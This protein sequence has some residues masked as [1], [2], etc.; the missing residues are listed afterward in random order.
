MVAFL[1]T[2]PLFSQE[3][4]IGNGTSVQVYP[5]GNYYGFER[6]ASL[7]QP[8]EIGNI[9][10]ISSLAWYANSGGFGSRPIKIYLKETTQNILT[11]SD[12]SSMITGATLVYD[13]SV[14]PLQGWNT[15]ILNTTFNYTGTTN[16]LLVLVEAN[17]GASGNGFG[18]S[19][20]NI[21]FSDAANKHMYIRGDYSAPT[22]MGT[23]TANRPNLKLKFGPLVTCFS[24]NGINA[25]S[26][27]T[28]TA[29]IS[30]SAAVPA[31]ANGY[32]YE[33]RTSGAAGSGST[34]LITSGT[35]A[36]G[37]TTVNITQLTNNTTYY[38]Y[39]RGI[40]SSTNMSIWSDSITFTTLCLSTNI[41]YNVPID[42][43]TIPA[44]PDCVVVENVNNDNRTWT[45][46]AAPSGFSGKAMRYLYHSTNV[47][48]DWFYTRGLNLTGGVSY[49][50]RFKYRNTGYVEKLR[51]SY[52]TATNNTA[53]TNELFAVVTQVTATTIEKFIDF[54]PA[55]TGV[56]YVG[57]QAFSDANKN[58]LYV[59]DIS[60]EL[61]P[62]CL[63]VTTVTIGSITQTTAT[64]NWMAPVPAPANGYSYEVRTS[65][66]AGSGTS[67]L[68]ASGTTGAGV[69]TA[70][71]V[72]L[73][74]NTT[75]YVYV[76][77]I[78][79]NTD[80]GLW[81]NGT[82]FTTLCN[83]TNIPYTMPI[84]A[85]VTPDIPAC[86]IVENVNNDDR[87][88]T[89]YPSPTGFT[90]KAM[91]YQYHST[92][93]ANDWFYTRGL[94]LTA[95]VSYRLK[96]KYRNVLYAE[97]LRVS[98]GT[99]QVNTA[100]LNEIFTVV[101]TNQTATV[102]KEIDFVPA[103]TGV[104]YI[105]FQAFSDANKNYLYVGDI[106]VELSPTCLEVSG[107]HVNSITETTAT[108]NWIAPATAPA[109]GYSYEI[110]TSGAAG[111]GTTGL[112]NSG[113]T[114]AGI[115]TVS[116]TQL[117]PSTT[118]YVYVRGVCNSTETGNWSASVTLTT[119]CVAV[120]I[121]YTVPVDA[122]TTPAIPD[123]V[124]VD[125]INNDNKTWISYATQPG[126]SGKVMGY[127]YHSTNAA[128]D[129]F[130]IRGLYMTAGVSYRLKFK[131]RNVLY[132]EKLRV[133][134]GTSQVNTAMLNEI[135]TV[136]TTSQTATVE[137][138]IDF[139]PTETGIHYI[140][141]QAFSDANKNYLYVGDISVELSPTCLDLSGVQINNITETSATIN[142]TAPVVP[143]IEGYSYEI[144]TSGAAGSGANG[145]I[146]SGTTAAGITT[147]TITQL[148]P[149]TTYYVY[150]RGICGG[151]TM[152][153]WTD[154][155]TFT[156]LCS[157]INVPYTVPIDAVTTPAIPDCVIVENVNNDNR[158]WESYN[159]PT[160]F[161]GKAMGYRYHS[162]NAANDWFYTRGLNLTAGVAYRLKFKYRN[163]L[164]AEKLRVSYGTSQVNTA[165][166]NEIF[167]VVTT[168]QTATVE[169]EID[170]VPA[171]TGVHYIGFQA[172]SDAYK[173][174]LYVGDISVELSPT[175][176]LPLELSVANVNHNSGSVNWQTPIIQPSNG[177]AYEL[178]TSGLPGE[179]TGLV[180]SGTM[181]G[182]AVT[183]TFQ[184]LMPLTTYYVYIKSVCDNNDESTWT[185]PVSFTTLCD[186]PDV[187][188]TT[189]VTIC[190]TGTPILS[191][192]T[193]TTGTLRWYTSSTSAIP[194]YTG[195]SFQTP[196]IS[197]T[198][199]F[200]VAASAGTADDNIYV[201]GGTT[202]SS[203][204]GYSPFAYNWGGYKY[205]YIYKA[206]EL[207]AAGLTAGPINSLALDVVTAGASRNDFTIYLGHTTQSAATTTHVSGTTMVYSNASQPVT[208]GSN[209]YTFATPFQWDGVSNVVVQFCWS[210]NNGG[211]SSQSAEI[212]YHVTPFNSL[213]VTYA[214]N[215][216]AAEILSTMTGSV[217]ISGG[218]TVY[219]N[220]A[221]I[222][223]NPT[224]MSPRVEVV[225]TVNPAPTL[226]L[227]TNSL[228]I[229]E[230]SNSTVVTVTTGASDYDV[231]IWEPSTGVAGNATA[232]WTF[233]PTQTMTYKLIATQSTGSQCRVEK[234]IT[235]KV[236]PQVIFTPLEDEYV[237]CKDAVQ[238]LFYEEPSKTEVT[239]GIATTLGGDYDAVTAF[240]NRWTYSK[241]Q[242]IYTK[243]ELN[244]LGFYQGKIKGFSFNIA[245]LG[246]GAT[247]QNYTIK[248]K[249]VENNVITSN[250]FV[251]DG[252]T[253][254]YGPV[255]HTH[256]NSGW[257]NIM[258]T[259]PYIWDGQSNLLVEI[260]QEGMNASY[261][262][263]TYYSTSTSNVGVV[264]QSG[265][266]A[267]TGT[268]TVRR[269]NTKFFIDQGEVVWSPATRLYTD[270][271]ATVP[272]VSGEHATRVYFKRNLNEAA[273]FTY[274]ILLTSAA[275]CEKTEDIT[276]KVIDVMTPQ[277]Q[278][279]LFC[280][281]VSVNDIVVTAEPN[282]IIRWYASA[283]ST[284]VLTS[285][286]TEGTYYVDAER[287]G[288]KS[289][290]VPA[291]ITIVGAQVPTA[292]AT[293]YFCDSASISDL[294]VA[295]H[296]GFEAR[297]YDAVS[298]TTPLTTTLGLVN[299]GVYYVATYHPGSGCESPRIPITVV[300][301]PT[302]AALPA[303]S[304][305]LCQATHFS[306]LQISILPNAILKWYTSMTA[307]QPISSSLI[308]SSG[309]Y[310]VSQVINGCESV[311]SQIQITVQ[312]ALDRP[313]ATTQNICGNGTVADLI[314]TGAVAGAIYNWY[315]SATSTTPLASNTA[316]TSG[317]YYV[318]Q[319]LTGCESPRRSVS[320]RVLSKQAPVVNA[321]S[322]CGL[323]RVSDL[324]LPTPTNISYRWYATAN[325]MIELTQNVAL[326][327]GTYYVARVEHGCVSERAAVP[328]TILDL[329]APP[330]GLANQSFTVN[331]INEVTIAD[332]EM[333]QTNIQWYISIQDAKT[334]NNP[335]SAVMPLIN[336]QTYYAVII[337]SNGCPSLPT[338]V[339]VDITLSIDGFDKTALVYYPNPVKD[340]LN[341]RYKNIIEMVEV[342]NLLGQKVLIQEYKNMSI[343]LNMDS[344]ASGSYLLKLRSENQVQIIKVV[345]K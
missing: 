52:G 187:L 296:Q 127:Q 213:T 125:N 226:E 164:Y 233:N 61:S 4:T 232:G 212:R 68:T 231:Y 210:N 292:P 6:S 104:Y 77:G 117:I 316:L 45:S 225:A 111:S 59:G 234:N 236:N 217:G 33:I 36:A 19:G 80:S 271:A 241:Q 72:Q 159:T 44:I 194:V 84:D 307:A 342:Y 216:T 2:L 143:P 209:Q 18:S 314:A 263:A 179:P 17:Y 160:G 280:D 260:Y 63:E 47:A 272:Y 147:V 277:V 278:E 96:F 161:T 136:V 304:I 341:I 208:V 173:N 206:D 3:V 83:A 336:A 109:N 16:N 285:I 20:N 197:A 155:T 245:S 259:T 211:V 301:T 1:I 273:D 182:D 252:F 251:T 192:T 140:G 116:V 202:A 48:N 270:E 244:A 222:I 340:I 223:F 142:W 224:C 163:V 153:I 249:D 105:G 74:P 110:R 258:F 57:F 186:Y 319:F 97:K 308:V 282:A 119:P 112:V 294:M 264:N 181:A 315:D 188:T 85:V 135:F 295:I 46:Y 121:P 137:K 22:A 172:F 11:T 76:K 297:W 24:P 133:S 115:T 40:C 201:G 146:N 298:S 183:K 250:T 64:L 239:V 103:T 334:G 56:Y 242:Y 150:V 344:L 152:G 27:T 199:S 131:Y 132:A 23:V 9:G 148:S 99:S 331:E 169:K 14:T 180:Q 230:G 139:I 253:T 345:K 90:G 323:A 118:Y 81:S 102:E 320:V 333:D 198:T 185:L 246:S 89:S 134:Y 108:I 145:L 243:E 113:T 171:T 214:D 151:S 306:E 262:A 73:T 51:V 126:F 269:M 300:I 13:A 82:V 71:I 335:L 318:S 21:R 261:N 287:S 289:E 238:E 220:R 49:R 317:V 337:G 327:T 168:A 95:G 53:M 329:P 268:L 114:A 79:S 138:V 325:G 26:I 107:V 78:C 54:V 123:C 55:T 330:T 50:L 37:V 35:T 122:V 141:F 7:Y 174:Y 38:V 184:T 312:S 207:I 332:L 31:P 62:S 124:V 94:N 265:S 92:N 41:P 215:K 166:L 227:S 221:N 32:S 178:R 12:W 69:T 190:G 86:V 8:S 75:Y 60:V 129:W 66:M 247:N 203:I 293:Q 255:T 167:T 193:E 144:R 310:Y 256:T 283:T 339:T 302:P 196:E 284:D 101:T 87:T 248:I 25:T 15:F 5:L 175:C 128:N 130:Y 176:L 39:V 34:G 10:N 120:N 266:N 177:Y 343:Q 195:A 322:F 28:T 218:T 156:T 321:F 240:M 275:G 88:W 311:R 43:V 30:W 309:T 235:V 170:F 91:G 274:T 165:M 290:R 237:V 200:Y 228:E 158:T 58:D 257:Q 267:S 191:A 281:A 162:S 100:M 42:A 303:Q 219:A 154:A 313:S 279:Q 70:N 286:D 229:C 324:S 189:P 149:F 204:I 205:Q 338:A 67:G 299:G 328:V 305:H 276:I 98:Y 326:T 93:T 29:V 288:C 157:A 106:S 65:G 254:V 291:V